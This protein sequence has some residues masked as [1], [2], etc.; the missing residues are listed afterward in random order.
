MALGI[1]RNP[2][3]YEVLLQPGMVETG[4][5]SCGLAEVA[6]QLNHGHAAVDGCDFAQHGEGV[7]A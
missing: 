7:V 6:A 5:Q 4:C 3:A 1:G 2:I